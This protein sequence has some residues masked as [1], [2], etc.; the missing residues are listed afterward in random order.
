MAN[1]ALNYGEDCLA[2]ACPFSL[3][4]E[5]PVRCIGD[6]CAIW[7]QSGDYSTCAINVQVNQLVQNFFKLKS[8]DEA[9]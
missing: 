2:R 1:M 7:V 4:S 3:G 5:K 6:D 8:I 9:L